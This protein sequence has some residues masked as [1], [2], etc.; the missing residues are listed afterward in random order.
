[1]HHP[2]T[3]P[4][5]Q[6]THAALL[7]AGLSGGLLPSFRAWAQAP[8]L[9]LAEAHDFGELRA[10]PGEQ[11]E[12]S[13][14]PTSDSKPPQPRS[15]SHGSPSA[16]PTDPRRDKV[17]DAS[18]TSEPR[19][20]GALFDLG[21]PDGAMAGISYRPWQRL[22]LHVAAGT[23]SVS[24]G[25]RAGVVVVPFGV[26]PSISLEAGHY[27]DGDANRTASALAGSD[28]QRNAMAERLGYDF[29]N[30]HLGLELGSEP[31]AFY[32]RGGVSYL[33]AKL[34]QVNEALGEASDDTSFAFY[35]EPRITAW[36][37]SF[38]VGFILYLT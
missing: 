9:A 29:A 37:P 7:A 13:M 15:L 28:Y 26:G 1:M 33:H 38:K 30:A 11:T 16:G 20:I 6:I 35:G 25:V 32:V 24:L 19:R 22:R 31:L 10:P 14:P 21:V 4:V 27:F 3:Q 8:E 2:R 17:A 5:R 12:P 23:N 18:E 34:H 36:L